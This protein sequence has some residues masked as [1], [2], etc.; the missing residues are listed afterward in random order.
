L[1]S[2]E[3]DVTRTMPGTALTAC[4]SGLVISFFDLE[5]PTPG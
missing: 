1:P 5:R 4:S 3:D 2:D